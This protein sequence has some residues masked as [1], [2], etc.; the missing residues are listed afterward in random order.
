MGLCTH[1]HAAMGHLVWMAEA[2]FDEFP[3]VEGVTAIESRRW[4]VFFPLGAALRRK[5]V[6]RIGRVPIP[7]SLTTFPTMRGG[8]KG[9]PWMEHRDGRLGGLGPKTEDRNLPIK[10]IVNDTRLKEMLV[11]DWRPANR[12]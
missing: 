9:Q 1:R 8:G 11:A 4:P 2:F 5:I 7:P 12:W 3:T 10:M 6:D